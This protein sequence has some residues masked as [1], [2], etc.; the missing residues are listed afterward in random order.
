M[1]AMKRTIGGNV[2]VRTMLAA[3]ACVAA[4]GVGEVT[5]GPGGGPWVG[6]GAAIPGSAGPGM[7][8][9]TEGGI[10]GVWNTDTYLDALKAQLAITPEQEA[11]WKDYADTVAGVGAQLQG[12]HQLIFEA[13]GTASWLE[14]RRLMNRMLLARQQAFD[15]VHESAIGLVA[16]LDPVQKTK[17]QSI[18]P[19]LVRGPGMMR[20]R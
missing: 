20:P 5:A 10:D 17:A 9:G 19:G 4:L 3:L 1:T 16:A 15:M 11:A 12:L 13:M 2:L 8:G 14:R 18:L 6:P 7:M